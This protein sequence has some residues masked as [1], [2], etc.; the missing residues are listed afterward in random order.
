M[1]RCILTFW[2][3][4]ASETEAWHRQNGVGPLWAGRI[5]DLSAQ[6]LSRTF[7]SADGGFT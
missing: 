3:C 1:L 7:C 4:H 2:R 5:V 6:P